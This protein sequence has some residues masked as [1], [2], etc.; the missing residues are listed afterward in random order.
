M[1]I[2]TEYCGETITIDCDDEKQA[3]RDL[4]KEKRKIKAGLKDREANRKQALMRAYEHFVMIAKHGQALPDEQP[5]GWSRTKHPYQID[6]HLYSRTRYIY[7]ISSDAG[8]AKLEFDEPIP[9]MLENACGPIAIYDA[10]TKAWYS[11]GIFADQYV[12]VE[13]PGYM[14][15]GIDAFRESSIAA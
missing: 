12:L 15:N 10:V 3:L 8:C 2:T 4:A 9:W 11:I 13:I 14:A 1:T 6:S 7:D 5:R